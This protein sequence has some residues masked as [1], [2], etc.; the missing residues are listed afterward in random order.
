[1]VKKVRIIYN[2]A[3]FLS[4]LQFLFQSTV[5]G[6]MI[7]MFFPIPWLP[8]SVDENAIFIQN[9]FLVELG[10]TICFLIIFLFLLSIIEIALNVFMKRKSNRLSRLLSILMIIPPFVF[11]FYYTILVLYS[12]SFRSLE[13]L[14]SH[15]SGSTVL[16]SLLLFSFISIMNLIISVVVAMIQNNII[17]SSSHQEINQST[18]KS[19]MHE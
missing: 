2:I 7:L 11:I 15:T 14:N 10:Y 17:L 18:F 6:L 12:V 9:S 5:G 16:M 8:N 3:I 4:V 19:K 13:T 1:M